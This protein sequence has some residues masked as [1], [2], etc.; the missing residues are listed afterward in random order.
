M[1]VREAPDLVTWLKAELEARRAE[2]ESDFDGVNAGEVAVHFNRGHV[3]VRVETR[4]S[5]TYPPSRKT[6]TA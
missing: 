2:I 4:V 1:S 6:S 5:R 3:I